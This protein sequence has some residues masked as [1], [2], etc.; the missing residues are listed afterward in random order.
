MQIYQSYYLLITVLVEKFDEMSLK[1]SKKAFIIY[2]NFIK[3]NK[4]IRKMGSCIIQEFNIKMGIQFYEIDTK[5]I[6][7]L[8]I[9]I[10]LKERNHAIKRGG[11]GAG[12]MHLSSQDTNSGLEEEAQQVEQA[13]YQELLID[14]LMPNQGQYP[15]LEKVKTMLNLLRNSPLKGSNEGGT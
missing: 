11:G 6:E 14:E 9:S 13:K 2:T 12:S 10:E 3:I 5:V 7:A 15:K 1:D 8:K 4:E